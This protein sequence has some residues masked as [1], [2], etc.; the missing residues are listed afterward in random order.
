MNVHPTKKLEVYGCDEDHLEGPSD[1]R[2]RLG[3]SHSDLD[4]GKALS[5][6]AEAILER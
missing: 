2:T 4:V 6:N 1:V 3:S 5:R